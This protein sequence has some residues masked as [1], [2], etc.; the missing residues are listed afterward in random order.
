MSFLKIGEASK[1]L[2]IC[3]ITLRKWIDKNEIPH[4]TT[5][6]GHRLVDIDAYLEGKSKLEP[7]IKLDREKIFYCR[8]SSKKQKDDLER[9]IEMAKEN[10][11]T[12]EIISDIGSGINWKRRGFQSLLERVNRGDIEEVVVFHKDRMARFGFDLVESIFKLNNTELKI[13][14]RE[15]N[16]SCEEELAED[17]MSIV[18][19]FSCRQMGKRRYGIKNISI[20]VL[21]EIEEIEGV[22]DSKKHL[23]SI[24]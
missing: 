19:V 13:H 9:Q 12:Y 6:G 18:T 8:V 3:K 15:E 20:E 14:E 23:R 22:R 5:P 7:A 1:R 11:P 21:K 10:Y 17:L 4:R 2:G 16:K 24:S